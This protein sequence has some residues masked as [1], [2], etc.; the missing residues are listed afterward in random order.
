MIVNELINIKGRKNVKR[1]AKVDVSRNGRIAVEDWEE[2]RPADYGVDMDHRH[3]SVP[4]AV[5]V[6]LD[7]PHPVVRVRVIKRFRKMMDERARERLI[8]KLK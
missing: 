1:M 7:G 6:R 5:D 4:I 8:P 2:V 3:D